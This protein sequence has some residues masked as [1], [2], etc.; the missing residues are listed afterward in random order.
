[1]PTALR[2]FTEPQEGATYDDLLA[3][4]QETERLGFDAFFRSDHYMAIFGDGVPGPTDAWVTLGALARET[5]RIKL[6]TLVSPVTFRLPGRLAIIVAQV[7]AMS[8]GRV[9]LGLGAGWFDGEHAAYG[10]PFPPT[11]ERFDRLEE[12]L[13]VITGLWATPVGSRFDYEGTYYQLSDSPALPKPVQSPPPIMLGGGGK[14][15]TPALAARFAAEFNMPFSSV[16]R[17]KEQFDVVRAACEAAGRDPSTMT[18]SVAQTLCVGS[19]EAE[20]A[21]RAEAIGQSVDQLRA[22]GLGGTVPEVVDKVGRLVEAGAERIY[23]QTLDLHDLDHL[24]LV[25]AEVAPAVP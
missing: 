19:D 3:V 13:E 8:G 6:G 15:R 18:F 21:R 17:S 1:M 4:A 20:V 22:G 24:R 23:L 11:G 16:E 7:D 5:E 2:I 9:E 12:Q 10:I 25:A 14:K